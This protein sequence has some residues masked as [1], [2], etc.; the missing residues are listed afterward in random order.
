MALD[1]IAP[2][3][4]FDISEHRPDA[5]LEKIL[6]ALVIVRFFLARYLDHHVKAPPSGQGR[7]SVLCR[8]LYCMPSSQDAE[9]SGDKDAAYYRQR[10]RIIVAGGALS[11]GVRLFARAL[12]AWHAPFILIEAHELGMLLLSHLKE[13]ALF[14]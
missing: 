2:I 3:P 13:D 4:V 10:L 14:I 1:K 12:V 11:Q 6:V 8:P 5:V 9:K 7:C